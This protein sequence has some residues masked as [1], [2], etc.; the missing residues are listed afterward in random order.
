MGLQRVGDNL[1]TKHAFTKRQLEDNEK[2]KNR[3]R[4][5]C[6]TY[7]SDKGLIWG[8]EYIKQNNGKII[9]K[10]IGKWWAKT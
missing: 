9:D 7:K 10:S 1:A 5:I 6:K 4:N 8:L 3:V 2:G